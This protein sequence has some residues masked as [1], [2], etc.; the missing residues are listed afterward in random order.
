LSV[1]HLYPKLILYIRH[2]FNMKYLPNKN[3]MIFFKILHQGI[4]RYIGKILYLFL[5]NNTIE[6]CEEVKSPTLGF[7]IFLEYTY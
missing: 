5:H 7:Q 4:R 3:T 2:I 1:A 6:E